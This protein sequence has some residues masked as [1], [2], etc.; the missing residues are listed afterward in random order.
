MT[1]AASNASHQISNKGFP[2]IGTKH[3]GVVSVKGRSRV[4]SPA[5][6]RRALTQI[7]RGESRLE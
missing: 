5:A 1:P 4:P 6:R 2:L 3:F 7:A